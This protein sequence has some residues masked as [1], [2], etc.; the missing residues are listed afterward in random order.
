[1]RI[2]SAGNVGIGTSSP[3]TKLEVAG[4]GRFTGTAPTLTLFRTNSVSPSARIRMVGSD[5]ADKW[6]VATN[7]LVGG[8]G[9]EF[10]YAGSNLAFMSTAGNVGIGTSS[11]AYNLVVSNGGAS[12]IEFGPAY[13]GTANLIQHYNRSGAAYV[14]VVNDAAQ[15]R[16]NISGTERLRIDSSG[17]VGIG[18]SSPSHKLDVDSGSA[19]LMVNM[20]TTNANGGYIRFQSSGTSIADVGTGGQ[21][22]SGGSATDFGLNV[23]GANNL[24]FATNTLER[25][26]IDDSG[27]VGIGTSSP[28]YR[29]QVDGGRAMFTGSN[30]NYTVGIG[31]ESN[32]NSYYLGVHST[33]TPN[34]LFSNNSGTTT[35][36]LDYSGNLGIGTT[37]P[38]YKLDIA[39][40]D[41][42]LRLK[43]TAG[44]GYIIDQNTSSGFVSHIVYENAGMRFGTNSTERMRI[45]ASGDWMV[46]NTVANTASAYS[47]QAGCG[48]VNSDTHFEIA[49]TSNRAALEI[50]K[51]NANDGDL[52][53][54]RKQSTPVGSIGTQGGK[55][56][57]AL[58]GG[59]INI[60]GSVSLLGNSTDE[61]VATLA[62]GGAY[63]DFAIKLEVFGL[64]GSY[65]NGIWVQ[66]IYVAG[67][68]EGGGAT[69][70]AIAATDNV[71][72]ASSDYP[73]WTAVANG[74]DVDIKANYA[75]GAYSIYIQA[76]YLTDN[77]TLTFA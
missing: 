66:T 26:R 3:S 30:E 9:L 17:N 72:S 53:V 19:G 31:R 75:S 5:N 73:T 8:A 12:G 43:A 16:F 77:G 44:T 67:R 13:S 24:L 35:M 25:M 22:I 34:L 39:G 57:L 68:R 38:T 55:L 21:I 74:N 20:N 58:G 42:A 41:S 54:F 71:R 51:N 76:V 33:T 45:N 14:D 36:T 32:T 63:N 56:T 52:L 28:G 15:H 18:T 4:N 49:T 40:T 62:I 48:W 23:R 46:A 1:M 10:N 65:A 27:N 60:G 64:D 61:L 37:S 7:Y 70:V 11:P 47:T 29:L 59:P 2:T 50:G 69:G 6:E